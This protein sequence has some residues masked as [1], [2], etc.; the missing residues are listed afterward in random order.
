MKNIE[1]L[2]YLASVGSASAI[3]AGFIWQ[4]IGAI[5]VGSILLTA[6]ASYYFQRRMQSNIREYEMRRLRVTEVLG[7]LHGD[8]MRMKDVLD[9]NRSDFG[10]DSPYTWHDE[11]EKSSWPKIRSDYKYFL[12]PEQVRKESE[13]LF[14]DLRIFDRQIEVTREHISRIVKDEISTSLIFEKPRDPRFLVA[15]P[16]GDTREIHVS[17]LVFWKVKP[18]VHGTLKKVI[19]DNEGGGDYPTPLAEVFSESLLKSVWRKSDEDSE[20]V[21]AR[22]IHEDLAKRVSDLKASVENQVREWTK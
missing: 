13:S 14:S 15:S 21:K 5:S 4:Q 2:S 10:L 12:I 19:V 16:S 3:I 6:V 22:K 8:L 18:T 11:T 1:L 9:R 20:I 7:P 17:G